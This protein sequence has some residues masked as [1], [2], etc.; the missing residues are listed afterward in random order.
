MAERRMF[1]KT[2]IDSDAFLDMP[3]SSQALYFHLNMRA[4][5]DGFVNNPKRILRTIGAN[6]N[7]YDLILAKRFIIEF[8]SGVVVIKHWRM[9]NYIRIDRYKPTVYQDEKEQL[10][11]KEN[12]SYT[13]GIPNDNHRLTQDRLGKD[14]IGNIY[15]GDEKDLDTPKEYLSIKK[16]IE[17]FTQ[18]KE[19]QE[20]LNQFVLM[21]EKIKKKLTNY[22]FFRFLNKLTKLSSD[23]EK[24]TEIL[25]RSIEKSWSD[26]YPLE[27]NNNF[28]GN[29][30]ETPK[31]E[32]WDGYMQELEESKNQKQ[33]PKMTQ[34]EIDAVLEEAKK[35]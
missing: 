8:E 25:N 10:T 2:I 30:K 9:H 34:E 24:Q 15:I 33:K 16:Q 20:T 19:L 7:D 13:L 14:S 4:D 22:A 26:I 12:K 3:L 28:K 32:W 1:A 29:K 17:E 35:L 27:N 18:D 5:D 31:P 21:R 11:T 6:Q 23:K